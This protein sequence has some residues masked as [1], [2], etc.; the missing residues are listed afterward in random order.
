MRPTPK[1]HFVPDSQVGI[2]KFPRLGLS[3]LWWPIILCA[4]LWLK[5]GLKQ[6]YSSRWYLFNGMSYTT[7]MQQNQGNS[8]LLVAQSQIVNFTSNPSFGHNLCF[9][10]SNGSCEPILD[11]YVLRSFQWYKIFLNP[12]SFDP[13]NCP[14]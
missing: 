10:C 11:I 4:N 2:P 13:Y 14:L 5:W 12:M 3:Q 9:K 1:C 7:W 8:W 6:S